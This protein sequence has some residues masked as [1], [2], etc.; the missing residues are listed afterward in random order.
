MHPTNALVCPCE[1]SRNLLGLWRFRRVWTP[2]TGVYSN[3]S[4][5]KVRRPKPIE[6]NGRLL[7]HYSWAL[8]WWQ[9]GLIILSPSIPV[10]Y[11]N[12][13]ITLFCLIVSYSRIAL[14]DLKITWRTDLSTFRL[15]HRLI[16]CQIGLGRNSHEILVRDCG[17]RPLHSKNYGR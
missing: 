10:V 6:G 4:T 13:V 11:H 14:K 7:W 17:S 12:F 1:G 9:S 15:F 5:K 8:S 3:D 16:R 2:S